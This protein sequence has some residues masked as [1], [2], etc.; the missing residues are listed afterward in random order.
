MSRKS[1]KT[2][3]STEVSLTDGAQVKAEWRTDP[4]GES[5]LYATEKDYR[6]IKADNSNELAETCISIKNSKNH[7][8]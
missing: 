8:R 6:G 2:R 4:Y 7:D 1:S 5:Y 3:S